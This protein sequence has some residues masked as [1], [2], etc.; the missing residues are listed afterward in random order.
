MDWNKIETNWVEYSKYIKSNWLNLTIS[1]LD[2]IG[3]KR[4]KLCKALQETYRWNAEE[5]E[6]HIVE[7]ENNFLGENVHLTS[8]SNQELINTQHSDEN[9]EVQNSILGSPFHKGY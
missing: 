6:L 3:G 8:N 9:E 5:A 4:E 2:A 7:W 1:Q